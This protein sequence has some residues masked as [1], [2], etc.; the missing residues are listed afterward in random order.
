MAERVGGMPGMSDGCAEMRADGTRA[1]GTRAAGGRAAP[2]DHGDGGHRCCLCFG[3][4]CHGAPA[5]PARAPAASFVV[6]L[7]ALPRPARVAAVVVSYRPTA[8]EH[9]RPPSVGPPA[10]PAS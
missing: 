7:R 3:S 2:G 9:A 4:C 8:P 10:G 6:V 5:V 1:D